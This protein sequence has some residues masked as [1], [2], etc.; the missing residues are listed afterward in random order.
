MSAF[1]ATPAAPAAGLSSTEQQAIVTADRQHFVH[2]ATS[3]ATD[4]AARVISGAQGNYIY[5]ADGRAVLDG[6][7]GLWCVNI[8]HARPEMAETLA[9]ASMQLDYFHTFSGMTNVYAA[10]LA[11]RLSEL[12]PSH[13]PHVYFGSS[14]SDANDT[15]L[16]MVWHYNNILGRPQKKKILSRWQAYHGT[17][18]S[19]ASLTGLP[20]FH[21]W[22]DL[23]LEQVLHL[24]CPHYYRFGEAG[25]SE[26]AFVDR[27][28][29]EAEAVI[30]R[31]GAE[32][33]AAFIGEP[34]MGAGGVIVPPAG[35]WE[36]MQALMRQ[37]DILVIADEVISGYGRCGDWFAS[38]QMGIQ[39]DL[40]ATA[41]GLTSGVF[42]MSA[43]FLS[44][45]IFE[46]LQEGSRQLGNFA[47]G[48]TYSGHPIGCAV[49]LTNLAIMEREQLPAQ[50][51]QVGQYLHE[52]LQAKLLP[53]AHVGEIRGQALL[54]AVQLVDDKTS[55]QYDTTQK[56]P[57]KL[58][59]L[60]W[61][62]GL[63][64]RPLPTINAMAISPPLT[65]TFSEVDTLVERLGN[66][67]EQL[68]A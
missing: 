46:V 49:G 13:L 64:V 26:E 52:Q 63:M 41:K 56:R 30:E 65:L 47:H 7:A 17:S 35:Y 6:T 44:E 25:E 24:S 45:A 22:F 33:I 20:G 62:Q 36:R 43:V 53:H 8:G 31:E 57:A 18:I 15:I 1:K 66:S 60:C 4:Q 67:L 68:Y 38:P 40:M 55:R 51:A 32:T 61:Q 16:K 54:A 23:P 29:A 19:A 9:T 14:G 42:P 21:K 10:Q 27:L 58:A 59:E 28:V 5:D 11:E 48:Y 3:M 39:A 34:I 37:H 50:A 2:P 12:A